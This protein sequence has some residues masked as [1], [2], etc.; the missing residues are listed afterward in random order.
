MYSFEYE[1]PVRVFFGEGSVA[2]KLGSQFDVLGA[3]SCSH[4]AVLPQRKTVLWMRFCLLSELPASL[5]WSFPASC[6]ILHGRKYRLTFFCSG[7]LFM[8]RQS[9]AITALE[10]E[11]QRHSLQERLS[12]ERIPGRV[13]RLC[14]DFQ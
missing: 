8:I 5:L 14:P 11:S 4:T 7:L 10:R 6:L 13:L 9:L 3:E 1:Y 2:E 12:D